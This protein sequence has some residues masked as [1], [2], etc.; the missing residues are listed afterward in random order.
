MVQS[1][2]KDVDYLEHRINNFLD[3][4]RTREGGTFLP[5]TVESIKQGIINKLKQKETSLA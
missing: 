5:E 4:N 3:T 1:G 2:S